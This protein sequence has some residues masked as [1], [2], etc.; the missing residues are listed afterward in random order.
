MNQS[1]SPKLSI[2]IGTFNR[3][4]FLRQ[5][6]DSILPQITDECEIIVSDNASSD[7]TEQVVTH[8]ML[9]SARLRYFRQSENIGLD[10][11]FDSV[12]E[13]A[14]G[15]YCW[16]MSDDDLLK[17]GAVK[18]V[19]EELDRDLS[20]IVVNMEWKDY[21]MS[22]VVQRSALDFDTDR[23]YRPGQ[24]DKLFLE[25]HQDV[26][27]YVG[28][29]VIKREIWLSRDKSPYYGSLFIQAGVIFQKELPAE[30]LVIA[31][32]LISYRLGNTRFA[33]R[34]PEVICATWPALV[35][36]TAVSASARSKVPRA[37]PWRNPQWLLV[38][39][40]LGFYSLKEYRQWI[41]PRLM[42]I[43]E[44][45]L[46]ILVA[47]LPGVLVNGLMILYFSA[48]RNRG[49]WVQMMKKSRFYYWDGT[50]LK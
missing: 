34:L 35:E 40:G 36:S 9:R 16:L 43:R 37:E 31:E 38:L 32:P 1:S 5:A 42:S 22:K 8:Y 29:T 39:R 30:T 20:L 41:R 12:V 21:G 4:E 46:T 27:M 23:T 6:L 3:A 47:I 14:R 15:E 44:R 26:I 25:V 10:R 50:W 33:P 48:R 2:C 19:L 49:R 45:F 28:S 18:R 17:P 11:N 7:A 13:R 24:L